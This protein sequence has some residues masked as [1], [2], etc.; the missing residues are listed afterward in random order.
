[1]L[2]V[3]EAA[4]AILKKYFNFFFKHLIFEKLTL[5][6]GF[7]PAIFCSILKNYGAETRGQ[8]FK[9]IFTQTGNVCAYG[10]SS[11]LHEKFAPSHSWHLATVA[12]LAPRR[13]VGAK[14][15]GAKTF[16]A[17]TFGAK[18]FGA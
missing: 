2:D 18:T 1:V 4:S 6:R 9:R 3:E 7:Q 15:F 12:M 11:H 10:K 8:F 5:W 14:T 17:K 16:G 13:E